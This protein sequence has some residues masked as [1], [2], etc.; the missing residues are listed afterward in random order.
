MEIDEFTQIFFE[1]EVGERLFSYRTTA[2]EVLWDVLRF[3]QF[4]SLFDKLMS[5]AQ[6]SGRHAAPAGRGAGIRQIPSKIRSTLGHLAAIRNLGRS[7]FLAYICSRYRDEKGGHIDFATADGC[8]ELSAMGSVRRIESLPDVV[9]DLNVATIL[10]SAFRLFRLPRTYRQELD[11]F[12]R[13][14]A[15]AEARYFGISDV[16]A[17][18]QARSTYKRHIIERRMWAA[19]LDR[20]RPGLI[21]MVQSGI[22]KGMLIEAK[23]RRIPVVE[24][25][26]G[27]INLMHLAYAYPPEALP[28][29]SVLVPDAL[30][31][32]S[33]YWEQQCRMPGTKMIAAGNNC[34]ASDGNRSTRAGA[35]VIIDA[36]P[37]HN[38]LSPLVLELAKR[39]PER[40]FIVKLHPHQIRD[41]ESIKAE[42]RGVENISII[43]VERSCGD[44]FCDVSDVIIVESTAAYEALDRGIPVHI[45]RR[46][47][48]RSHQ[49]L[50]SQPDVALFSTADELKKNLNLNLTSPSSS[51]RYFEHFDR[52]RFRELVAK[53][54]KY[55]GTI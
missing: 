52:A 5:S 17:A 36:Q 23:A 4:S 48:Y 51:R 38:Y 32:L 33:G 42:Y 27:V 53:L 13:V 31:L 40:R 39:M 29:E 15:D 3:D 26:H 43:G 12:S 22:Q 25:Q 11:H 7:D 14:I 6:G 8:R 49:D 24:A 16:S 28:Q 20:V 55:S 46:A 30:L 34:F 54:S 18:Q 19:I 44:L 35:T 45:Y 9:G 1:M 50:F 41:R 10:S 21:L 37:F 2:G 47:G